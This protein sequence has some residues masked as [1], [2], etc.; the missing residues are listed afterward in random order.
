MKVNQLKTGVILSY[1]QMILGMIISIVY[2]PFMLR[3]LGQSEYG[4]YNISSSVIAYLSILNF[5]FGSSYIRY[6]SK[7]KYLGDERKIHSLNGMFILVF[8]GLGIL[9]FICGITLALNVK[10]LFGTGLSSSELEIIKIL[11]VIMA[12]N[13]ALSFP[14]SVFVSFI[15]ANERF[16]FQKIVNM[17]KTVFSPF[18]TL[19]VLFCGFRSVGMT[20]VVTLF[21][22]ITDTIN[23]IYCIKYLKMKFNFKNM[24]WR[25]FKDIAAFSGFI[26]INMIVDEI[27]W[28]VDKFLL[29]RFQGSVVTAVYG[30]AATLN[31]YYR[32][33]S[34]SITNVFTPRIHKIV[35]NDSDNKRIS[36]LLVRIGRI[37]FLLLSLIWTGFIFFGKRFIS[38]WAGEGYEN[39]YY[40]TL[41]LIIPVTFTLIQGVGIEIQ[42]AKNMHQFRSIAYGIM[43][44][45][46][47]A[48]SIPLCIYWGG[49]GVALG[50]AISILVGNIIIMNWYYN[51]KIGLDIMNFWIEIIKAL[52]GLAIPCILGIIITRCTLHCNILLYLLMI[53]VYVITYCISIYLFSMN[54]YE[55]NLVY[56]FI[57]RLIHIHG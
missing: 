2:T 9:A 16:V 37:Q 46:N 13:M 34:T 35:N 4:L 30:V 8:C 44:I 57:H 40:I 53:I 24:D 56:S 38:F 5:G 29:G 36:D 32:N 17:I 49:I 25:L 19:L 42:R 50:T 41:L 3:F 10:A 6:Y 45:I 21:A 33:I 48:V 54:D 22:L 31:S 28:N 23:V 52:R 14:G 27:N 55:K 12:F 11:M 43:A 20:L 26:A 15:T 18:V 1:V 39:A 7:Y 47:I 51:K